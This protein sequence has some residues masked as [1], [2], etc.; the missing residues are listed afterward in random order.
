MT[1]TLVVQADGIFVQDEAEEDHEEAVAYW[2]LPRRARQV[3]GNGVLGVAACGC[4]NV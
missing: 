2:V 1:A 3:G 4:V